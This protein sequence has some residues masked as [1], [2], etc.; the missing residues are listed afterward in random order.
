MDLQRFPFDQQKIPIT[1]ESFHWKDADMKLV[2]LPNHAKQVPSI[3]GWATMGSDFQ[4]L[5][6][7]VESI[8]VEEK[9]KRYEFEDRQY[10]QIAVTIHLRRKF[11][12]YIYKVIALL[13]LIV[14]M[15]WVAFGMDPLGKTLSIIIIMGY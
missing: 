9:V 8:E 2:R 5:E 4:M 12:Y 7:K 6:W 14:I 10:S 15:S 11:A 3:A 13:V 1:F